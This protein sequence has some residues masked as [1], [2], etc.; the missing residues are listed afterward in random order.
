[1]NVGPSPSSATPR[2]A[3]EPMDWQGPVSW[4]KSMPVPVDGQSNG[5]DIISLLRGL[6]QGASMS[7]SEARRR[8]RE[9]YI[10]SH[11]QAEY[12]DIQSSLRLEGF[13]DVTLDTLRTWRSRDIK[14]GH[15]KPNEVVAKFEKISRAANRVVDKLNIGHELSVS[16]RSRQRASPTSK[17]RTS[18]CCA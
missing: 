14:A 10:E 5:P 3:I 2:N 4:D 17:T 13:G 18:G 15:I 7:A 8:A 12:P 6:F 11:G 9:L 16:R 1:M